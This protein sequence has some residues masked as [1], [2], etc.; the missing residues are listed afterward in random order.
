MT[1]YRL[2]GLVA[3]A[4][5]GCIILTAKTRTSA[6]ISVENN[7][8]ILYT[9]FAYPPSDPENV[10]IAP[11]Q[12]VPIGPQSINFQNLM[13]NFADGFYSGTGDSAGNGHSINYNPTPLNG[14]L[15][16]DEYQAL[17]GGEDK[18]SGHLKAHYVPGAGDPPLANLRFVQM[19]TTNYPGGITPSSPQGQ[20]IDGLSGVVPFYPYPQ[21]RTNNLSLLF[22]D[23]PSR[24]C[25]PPHYPGGDT[26]NWAASLFVASY[27]NTT[28]NVYTG[29]LWG[30]QMICPAVPSKP[31]D[32]QRLSSALVT[33]ADNYVVKNNAPIDYVVVP[34][35]GPSV[36]IRLSQASLSDFSNVIMTQNGANEMYTFSASITGEMSAN[37]GQPTPVQLSGLVQ[38]E[39]LGRTGE[40][41][42]EFSTE[43][44]AMN[45][46]GSANLPGYGPVSLTL[47]ESPTLA[48]IGTAE[49]VGTLA[50]DASDTLITTG[51]SPF[52]INSFFDVFTELSINGGDFAPSQGG[53]TEFDL[54]PEP[55]RLSLTIL[56][57]AGLLLLFRH[58]GIASTRRVMSP[59]TKSN[60]E[61]PLHRTAHSAPDALRRTRSSRSNIQHSAAGIST[62]HS[63]HPLG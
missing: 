15:I 33:P 19:V 29:L 56:G 31:A 30:W 43:M 62:E 52:S 54:V 16:V 12:V 51:V 4:L 26:I 7:P 28:L 27:D 1:R 34:A 41:E 2:R 22:T 57:S 13:N 25:R 40:A 5:V 45:M 24:N 35:I 55:G 38:I 3:S 53:S 36:Q 32:V 37:S 44:L 8:S 63:S 23:Y 61:N 39:V 50:I 47:R 59:N 46:I 60:D 11:G 49:D 20:R 9:P 42:G 17:S 58:R 14:T 6:A 10:L 18:G 21:P 48:S